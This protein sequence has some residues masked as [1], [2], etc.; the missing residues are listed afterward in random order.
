M[1]SINPLVFYDGVV[2]SWR[3]VPSLLLV[4]RSLLVFSLALFTLLRLLGSLWLCLL[5]LLLFSLLGPLLLLLRSLPV[6]WSGLFIIRPL[7]TL[8]SSLGF[9]FV[10]A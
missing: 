8:A 9:L 5:R 4:F 6:V 2:F 1:H 7:L 3:S 10:A